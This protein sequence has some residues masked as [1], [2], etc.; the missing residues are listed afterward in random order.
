MKQV[1]DKIVDVGHERR[2]SSQYELIDARDGISANLRVTVLEEGQKLRHQHV[3]G[4]VQAVRI[5]TVGGVFADLQ[6][7]AK[8]SFTRVVILGV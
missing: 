1:L 6:Q 8:S 2:R 3:Q 5:E 7:S 4:P